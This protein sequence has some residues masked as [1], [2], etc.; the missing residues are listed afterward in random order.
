[1]KGFLFTEFLSLVENQCDEDT[2]D[3]LIHECDLPSQGAYTAVGTYPHQEFTALVQAYARHTDKP[4]AE[5]LREYGRH[6]LPLL[7]NRYPQFIRTSSGPLEFLEDVEGYVHVE[8][9]KFYPEA[10]LPSLKTRRLS[11]TELEVHYTSQR[12]LDDFCH[13]L[14]EGALAHFHRQGEVSKAATTSGTLFTVRLLD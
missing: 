14:I 9:S 8:A 11:P 6:L 13:G 7:A 10:E 1:M 2:V 3:D 5:V 12:H 4:V